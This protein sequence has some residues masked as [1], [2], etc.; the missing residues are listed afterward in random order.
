MAG[1]VVKFVSLCLLA[2]FFYQM[3]LSWMK[4]QNE[5]FGTT[6]TQRLADTIPYPSMTFCPFNNEWVSKYLI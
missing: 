1:V 6:V 5:T 4:L 3:V 2:Y